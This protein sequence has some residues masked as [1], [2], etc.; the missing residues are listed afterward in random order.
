[1][2]YQDLIYFGYGSDGKKNETEF[3]LEIKS[4]FPN[5]ELVD[6]YDG[7]KGYRQEIHLE[8]HE[9]NN[10]WSWLIAFGWLELSLTG[11]FL[12]LGDHEKLD[13]YIYLSKSQYPEKFKKDVVS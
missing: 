12:L 2:K 13:H 4:K 1:M 6:C 10:Y 11:Q 3:I 7:I 9:S 5:V 8:E